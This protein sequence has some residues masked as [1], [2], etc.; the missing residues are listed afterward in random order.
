MKQRIA[1][2]AILSTLGGL[3]YGQSQGGGGD[4]TSGWSA[5][6][7]V[8][9][10]TVEVPDAT[11]PKTGTTTFDW[12]IN[13]WDYY[14]KVV[15]ENVIYASI[16][17]TVA[18]WES[19]RPNNLAMPSGVSIQLNGSPNL[20]PTYVIHYKIVTTNAAAMTFDMEYIAYDEVL[21]ILDD[22]NS[23]TDTQT[24]TINP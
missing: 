21:G 1:L 16:K 12:E 17:H 11:C 8:G 3:A 10:F 20:G 15:G 9:P 4:P 18:A 7:Y 22:P 6:S 23:A 14:N 13:D 24:I 19:H 5:V 2:L